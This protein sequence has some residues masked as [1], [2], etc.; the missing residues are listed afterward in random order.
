MEGVR[1]EEREWVS[2]AAREKYSG[3]TN[4]AN[5]QTQLK[6]LGLR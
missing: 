6:S 3:M 2:G 5:R 4:V 1:K